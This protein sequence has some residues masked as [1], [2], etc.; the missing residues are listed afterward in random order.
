MTKGAEAPF[1][2]AGKR[3][4]LHS[5]GAKRGF[6]VPTAAAPRPRFVAVTRVCDAQAQSTEPVAPAAAAPSCAMAAPV[7]K[8][9]VNTSV[10]PAATALHILAGLNGRVM[11]PV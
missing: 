3:A 11:M 7:F 10:E 1:A 9:G 6:S 5:A 8:N 4:Y 2:L